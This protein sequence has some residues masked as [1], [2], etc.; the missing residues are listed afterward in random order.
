M[1]F[2][3]FFESK[4][5]LRIIEVTLAI[6]L[7]LLVFA[8]GVF[9]GTERAEFSFNWRMNY[10]HNFIGMP[11]A[12]NG[13]LTL[14]ANTTNP[15]GS[16]GQIV[17]VSGSGITIIGSTGIAQSISIDPNTVIKNSVQTISIAD[18]KPNEHIV[19]IGNPNNAG[20]IVAKFI[21]VLPTN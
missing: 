2:Q 1:K 21:R 13:P 11:Q 12:R 18:L 6:I 14:D 7:L 15:R 9:V 10:N 16:S 3:Q 5:F 20:E 17:S 19:V 8:G 4:L